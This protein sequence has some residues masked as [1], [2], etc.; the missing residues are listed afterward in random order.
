MSSLPGAVMQ[1]CRLEPDLLHCARHLGALVQLELSARPL[2][3]WSCSAS[4]PSSCCRC[5]TAFRISSSA[6]AGGTASGATACSDALTELNSLFSSPPP[7]SLCAA[8]LCRG[9]GLQVCEAQD[10]QDGRERGAPTRHCAHP[11]NMPA[12][13]Q[14]CSAPRPAAWSPAPPCPPSR[15]SVA[16]LTSCSSRRAISARCALSCSSCNLCASSSF[17]RVAISASPKNLT[18]RNTWAAEAQAGRGCEQWRQQRAVAA[19]V[20][21]VDLRGVWM[22]PRTSLMALM[23]PVRPR[24][25]LELGFRQAW[26]ESAL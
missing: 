11:L 21:G 10:G 14:A 7:T 13:Q 20:F 8:Q 9:V 4:R 18:S 24:D 15:G 12:A 19:A 17:F 16:A 6:C 23:R 25:M 1:H 3:R 26:S 5:S 22:L 2:T